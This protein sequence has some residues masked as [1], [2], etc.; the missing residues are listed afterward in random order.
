MKNY[1]EMADSVFKRSHDILAQKAK[2][3]RFIQKV[4]ATVSCC[5]LVA[6]LGFGVWKSGVFDQLLLTIPAGDNSS[7]EENNSNASLDNIIDTSDIST[8][9]TESNQP[10]SQESKPSDPPKNS[11]SGANNESYPSSGDSS[12]EAPPEGDTPNAVYRT[13]SATY[14]EAKRL[15]GYPIVECTEEGFLGYELAVI[16][17]DGDIHHSSA[18]YLSVIYL[19]ESGKITITDQN[20]LCTGAML[21]YDQYPSEEYNGFTF[22]V[23]RANNTIYLPLQDSLILVAQFSDKQLTETYNLMLSVMLI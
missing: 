14:E 1:K 15:F 6:L 23:D 16:S 9:T 17:P 12:Q 18:R 10:E 20:I 21:A 7:V 2:K 8:L 19:F 5:C 3:K 13:L 22:W 11:E 4:S